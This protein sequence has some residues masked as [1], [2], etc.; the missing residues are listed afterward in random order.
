MQAHAHTPGNVRVQR[1]AQREGLLV[2]NALPAS[3]QTQS[4]APGALAVVVVSSSTRRWRTEP[5][6]VTRSV[7]PSTFAI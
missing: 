2:L 1:L 6:P 7:R 5:I 4:G 3:Q